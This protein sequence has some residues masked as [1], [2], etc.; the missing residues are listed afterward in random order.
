MTDA[1]AMAAMN[2]PVMA[3]P[4]QK[5]PADSMPSFSSNPATS[6]AAS[7]RAASS[8]SGA[9]RNSLAPIQI[10]SAVATAT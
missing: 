8:A 1:V 2:S 3:A 7:A 6:A 10:V 4:N 5:K 9:I